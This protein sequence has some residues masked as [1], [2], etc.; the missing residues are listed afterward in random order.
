MGMHN[1]LKN[2]H[3][4]MINVNALTLVGCEWFFKK[5]KTKLQ[6]QEYN[7]LLKLAE[8]IKKNGLKN[9]IVVFE[10]D[11]LVRKDEKIHKIKQFIITDGR[12]RYLAIK[13]FL[14]FRYKSI[15][16]IIWK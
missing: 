10:R 8:D 16:C 9:P 7:D 12:H 2:K 4:A 1:L 5:N 15:P 14:T 11:R 3:T 13:E 6:Q